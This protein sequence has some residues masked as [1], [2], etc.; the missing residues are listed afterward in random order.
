MKNLIAVVTCAQRNAW[1][2]AI[3]KTWAPLFVDVAD[4]VFFVGRDVI[5]PGTVSLD[6]DDS[7]QGLPD[8]VREI[9]RWSLARD[10]DFVMKCD[11]D[12]VINPKVLLSS[13]FESYDF[14]GHQSSP[15]SSVPYG[16]N[17]WLSKRA[18]SILSTKDLP[19]NNNDEAWVAHALR[20]EGIDLHHDPRYKLHMVYS[21]WKDNR[22]ALRKRHT[23]NDPRLNYISWCL[24]NKA[25]PL[26]DA[27]EEFDRLHKRTQE[28]Q[29]LDQ[30]P[31]PPAQ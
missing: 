15:G 12:V 26:S 8:K 1:A 7:Y 23:D 5:L 31:T 10:Y 27:L 24:H 4:V 11:D 20:K 18:L 28:V 17:Y 19:F 30:K 2:D 25:A 6:C 29:C 3:R 14:S 9:V 22:R 16:F 21:T 13:G